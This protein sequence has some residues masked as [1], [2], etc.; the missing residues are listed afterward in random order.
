MMY[1]VVKEKPPFGGF[2]K[3]WYFELGNSSYRGNRVYKTTETKF[4]S[5]SLAVTTVTLQGFQQTI[6]HSLL[7]MAIAI[8]VFSCLSEL[9]SRE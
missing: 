2:S 6:L 3:S 1:S 9:D 5:I 4:C 7:L 8:G